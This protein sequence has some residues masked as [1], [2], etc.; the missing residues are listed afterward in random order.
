MDTKAIHSSS[1]QQSFLPN[2]ASS[3]MTFSHNSG[4][5][6]E[7]SSLEPATP[8]TDSAFSIMSSV[9]GIFSTILSIPSR[10]FHFFTSLV[11]YC[12]SF[13]FRETPP[14]TVEQAIQTL[15]NTRF[16]GTEKEREQAFFAGVDALGESIREY[17]H[18]FSWTYMSW[19]TQNTFR[20]L[21]AISIIEESLKNDCGGVKLKLYVWLVAKDFIASDL[22]R[23]SAIASLPMQEMISAAENFIA[24]SFNDADEE[25]IRARVDAFMALPE[26]IQTLCYTDYIETIEDNWIRKSAIWKALSEGDD[27]TPLLF[28]LI[29]ASIGGYDP[30]SARKC[31]LNAIRED[32]DGGEA[33]R[34]IQSWLDYQTRTA[35]ARNAT[36]IPL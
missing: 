9:N 24:T 26:R 6:N 31:V 22:N 36:P 4:I 1:V 3:P 28:Q 23:P 8:Q 17:L 5:G 12:T 29:K 15:L 20:G 21:E 11:S 14:A 7:D 10:L 19:H 27:K 35:A 16:T 13:C 25:E 32:V 18:V 34:I 33:K 2:R 30:Q